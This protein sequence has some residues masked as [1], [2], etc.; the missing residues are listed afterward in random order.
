M[1]LNPAFRKKKQDLCKAKLNSRTARDTK[2]KPVLKNKPKKKKK[3]L[4]GLRDGTVMQLKALAA[5]QRT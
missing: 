4:S 3:S 2:R 5:P 1:P